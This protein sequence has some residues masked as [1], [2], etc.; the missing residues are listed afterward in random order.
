[1]EKANS[2]QHIY[3]RVKNP[4]I[5]SQYYYPIVLEF[6]VKFAPHKNQNMALLSHEMHIGSRN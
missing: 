6:N 2:T 3:E 5:Q 1:M 4:P